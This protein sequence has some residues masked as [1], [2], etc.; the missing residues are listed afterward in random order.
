MLIASSSMSHSTLIPPKFIFYFVNA[1]CLAHFHDYDPSN[2]PR[3]ISKWSLA[4]A[5]FLDS[6]VVN[7]RI[8]N[9][10]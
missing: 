5:Q 8:H 3:L 2:Y 6:I 4:I 10:R 7:D 1:Q 9:Y